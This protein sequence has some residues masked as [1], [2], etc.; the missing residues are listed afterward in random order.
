M[1]LQKFQSFWNAFTTESRLY[2]YVCV[3]VVILI[4]L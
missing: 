2:M 1:I 4:D 3:A